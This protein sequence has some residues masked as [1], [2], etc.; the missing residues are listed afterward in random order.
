MILGAWMAGSLFMAFVA[1]R[2]FERADELLKSPPPQIATMINTLGPDNAR[3]FL[4]HLVGD[5]NRV[6][7]NSWEQAQLVLGAVL[8]GVLFFFARNRFLAGFSAAMLILVIFGHYKI[9]P[10]LN[11]LSGV[12]EFQTGMAAAAQRD[13]F[14]TLHIVYGVME[15]AKLLL[16]V[17]IAGF[18]FTFSRRRPRPKTE[19]DFVDATPAP[20]F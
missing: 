1:T 2:N 3:L 14:W 17:V 4:R 9:T 6:F 15:A 16:G 7:F 12:I 18:L 5:E 10:E 8:T 13:Q 19:P 11:W 20:R